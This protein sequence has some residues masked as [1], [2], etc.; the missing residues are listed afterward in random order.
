M[1]IQESE[2]SYTFKLGLAKPKPLENNGIC[3]FPYG[4]Y[5][6]VAQL[7][8]EIHKVSV[9]GDHQHLVPTEFQKGNYV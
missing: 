7:A 1:H 4:V 3:N 2:S 6:N 8:E 9:V 5:D